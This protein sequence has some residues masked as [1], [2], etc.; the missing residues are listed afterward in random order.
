MIFDIIYWSLW[1]LLLVG[2]CL[3]FLTAADMISGGE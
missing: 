2:L 1:Y 3:M